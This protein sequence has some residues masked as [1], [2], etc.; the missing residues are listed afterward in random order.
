MLPFTLKQ[1]YIIKTVSNEKNITKAADLLYLSQP[2]LSK[3]IKIL[4]QSL[5]ITL[6]NRKSNEL[7]LTENGKIFLQYC[8]RILD[9]CEESY[10]ALVDLKIGN[11][12]TLT[13]GASQ[14]IGTYLM[15][16][17]IALFRQNYPQIKLNIEVNSTRLIS[18]QIVDRHIDIA[19]IGGE[20]P[21]NLI[22]NLNLDFFIEDEL[23][24]IISQSHPFANKKTIKKEE[25]YNLK[26]ITLN[27]TSTIR[28]FI[29]NIL[30]QRSI[31]T[32][33]LNIIMQLNSIESIK[34]AVSLGLGVAFVSSSAIEKE[35][36]LQT[37]KIIQI[38]NIKIT[39]P[40]S[41]LTHS[42][43]YKSKAFHLFYNEIATLKK[44]IKKFRQF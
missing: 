16:Q 15:P 10:R 9:L 39:R 18:K 43:C 26:F 13:V 29:D 42:Q 2:Y 3:Q 31:N 22:K 30:Q 35:L 40:L 21:I 25:L 44:S 36:R 17:I 11:R 33:Q 37:I 14:T 27:A 5:K 1:L 19:I 24:L 4:E 23:N 7:T 8:E 6:F 34:T 20:V 41:I 38:E 12:G 32:N 28:H